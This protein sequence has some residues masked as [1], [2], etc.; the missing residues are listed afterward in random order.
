MEIARIGWRWPTSTRKNSGLVK[1]SKTG[2]QLAIKHFVMSFGTL[3]YH[4]WIASDLWIMLSIYSPAWVRPLNLATQHQ[5]CVE[6]GYI[7]I[8]IFAHAATGWLWLSVHYDLHRF[9]VSLVLTTI[10]FSGTDAIRQLDGFS[11]GNLKALQNY[12]QD[13]Q[14]MIDAVKKSIEV[15]SMW[16]LV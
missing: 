4:F 13:V 14:I 5:H 9:K 3:R 15:L 2:Y 1:A 8:R 6:L 16:K 10:C 12:S 11:P 7:R